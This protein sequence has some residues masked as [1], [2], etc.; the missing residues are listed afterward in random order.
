MDS[1]SPTGPPTRSPRPRSDARPAFLTPSVSPPR[2]LLPGG[3]PVD[4]RSTA[5]GGGGAE[6]EPRSRTPVA[7]LLPSRFPH[8]RWGQ[9]T[10]AKRRQ[11][12]LDEVFPRGPERSMAHRLG[13]E[14]ETPSEVAVASGRVI[15]VDLSRP[16]LRGP[17]AAC[18]ASEPDKVP[19]RLVLAAVSRRAG[20]GQ[21]QLEPLA[22]ATCW[23]RSAPVRNGPFDARFV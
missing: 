7:R 12:L 8:G 19:G 1:N 6:Q 23:T 10:A 17:L 22:G 4:V 14:S 3:G 18:P 21:K 2:S 20:V 11:R 15:S 9:R 5:H 13:I 16:V